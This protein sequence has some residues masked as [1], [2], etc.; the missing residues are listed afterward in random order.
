M[1]PRNPIRTICHCAGWL[2]P[3]HIN[4][5]LKWHFTYNSFVNESFRLYLLKCNQN[6]VY[7][8][9]PTFISVILANGW[10]HILI[11]FILEAS[12]SNEN[13]HSDYCYLKRQSP[14]P[15][16]L[17]TMMTTMRRGRRRPK[18][19]FVYKTECQN[20]SRIIYPLYILL[21]IFATMYNYEKGS[22]L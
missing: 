21:H 16:T 2:E 7:P 3:K 20:R 15:Q 1:A 11:H 17:K 18:G 5:F 10:I 14:Q 13:D 4:I 12:L 19:Y 8:F 22:P 9:I 6:W